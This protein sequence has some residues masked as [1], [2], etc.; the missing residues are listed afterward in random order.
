MSD[1]VFKIGLGQLQCGRFE[2]ETP[3]IVDGLITLRRFVSHDPAREA[4]ETLR[5]AVGAT[6]VGIAGELT[7]GLGWRAGC[8]GDTTSHVLDFNRLLATAASGFLNYNAAP[9]LRRSRPAD[10]RGRHAG[11]QHFTL[12]NA[13]D[14]RPRRGLKADREQGNTQNECGASPTHRL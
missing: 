14:I 2:N 6:L 5:L 7:A 1:L 10:Y 4:V 8:V 12:G 3:V 9:A 11:L 13:Q